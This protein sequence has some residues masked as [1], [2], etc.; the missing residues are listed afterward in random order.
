MTT[1]IEAAVAVFRRIE[2]RRDK[3]AKNFIQSDI[4]KMSAAEVVAVR[5]D[6]IN[7]I[8]EVE[9]EVGRFLHQRTIANMTLERRNTEIVIIRW[10]IIVAVKQRTLIERTE[11]ARVASPTNMAVVVRIRTTIVIERKTNMKERRLPH[12]TLLEVVT[13]VDR[14]IIR[15]LHLPPLLGILIIIP[16][17]T[18]IR[19]P[20]MR[21]P[22]FQWQRSHLHLLDRTRHI[23]HRVI[24]RIMMITATSVNITLNISIISPTGDH[25][26]PLHQVTPILGVRIIHPVIR[27][28]QVVDDQRST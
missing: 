22:L 16:I 18:I 20:I 17:I 4:G 12:L 3:K 6:I 5:V 24:I 26:R 7:H 9:V 23:I 28:T 21:L 15:T 2:N 27:T 1:V 19:T 10:R 13:I 14:A 11:T 25:M 8:V